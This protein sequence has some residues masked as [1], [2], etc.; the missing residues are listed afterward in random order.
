MERSARDSGL[1]AEWDKGWALFLR[2]ELFQL[3]ARIGDRN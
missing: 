1:D 2:M 3:G